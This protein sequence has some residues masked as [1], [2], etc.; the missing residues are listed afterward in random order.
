MIV[1]LLFLSLVVKAGR[2]RGNSSASSQSGGGGGG[3]S[4]IVPQAET[5]L[6]ELEVPAARESLTASTSSAGGWRLNHSVHIFLYL[7]DDDSE[8]F[9]HDLRQ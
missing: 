8:R 5:Q 1:T 6:K 9:Q 2:S 7:C 4:S 3:G